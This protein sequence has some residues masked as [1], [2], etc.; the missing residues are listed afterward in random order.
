MDN[1]N[2][3]T[4]LPYIGDI[5]H[6]PQNFCNDAYKSKGDKKNKIKNLVQ[7]QKYLKNR[8]KKTNQN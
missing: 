3:S 5:G 8:F 7:N 6:N 2:C 1:R 4:Q